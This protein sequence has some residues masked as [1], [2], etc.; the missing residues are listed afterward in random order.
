M[1]KYCKLNK[2]KTAETR[3]YLL[4]ASLFYLENSYKNVSKYIYGLNEL[5]KFIDKHKNYVLRIYYDDSIFENEEY[6]KLLDTFMLNQ[7]IELINFSCSK[8]IVENHHI[9]TFGTMLRFLPLFEK[10][11]YKII[12]ISDIDDINYD[13]IYYSIKKIRKMPHN[14]FLI[15]HS[16]YGKHYE[17]LFD[18]KMGFTALANIYIKKFRF[19]I[20][21]LLNYLTMFIQDN[22]TICKTIE[23]INKKKIQFNANVNKY[24]LCTYGIDEL[25][26]NLYMLKDIPENKIYVIR[27][28]C[29][30]YEYIK[31]IFVENSNNTN[32]I[33]RY[34]VDIIKTYYKKVDTRK[35]IYDLKKIIKFSV[36]IYD[37]TKLNALFF[38]NFI[39]NDYV[40]NMNKIK[41]ITMMY[42][43]KYP[44][45]FNKSLINMMKN[46]NFGNFNWYII[47]KINMFPKK[48]IKQ[49]FSNQFSG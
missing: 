13:H 38:K 31:E 8:F 49:M 29:D 10:S 41:K 34:L 20:D 17:Y 27:E 12:Y 11:D 23:E 18:N 6:T 4:S 37:N 26:L 14:I 30:L 47:K 15:T 39:Y 48:F 45:I 2:T 32:I 40:A 35:S 7:K 24:A 9:G 43:K 42:Y 19:N 44:N 22:N 46:D 1:D 21:I 16:N 28:C 5:V 25:F 3:K 36:Y 33:H